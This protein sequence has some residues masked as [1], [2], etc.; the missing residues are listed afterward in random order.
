MPPTVPELPILGYELD[1]NAFGNSGHLKE[2]RVRE[3]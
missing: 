3:S 2:S 1:W